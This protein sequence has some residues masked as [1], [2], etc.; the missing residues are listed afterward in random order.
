MRDAFDAPQPQWQD[1]LGAG[2]G[3][4]G[5]ECPLGAWVGKRPTRRANIPLISMVL[6][7]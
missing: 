5:A 1:R 7:R 4:I 3:E 6:F 2:N